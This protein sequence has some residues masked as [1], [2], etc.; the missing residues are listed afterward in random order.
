MA[1]PGLPRHDHY[2]FKETVRKIL[3]VGRAQAGNPKALGRWATIGDLKRT[4]IVDAG[5]SAR[6][7][8]HNAA[9][10]D[11]TLTNTSYGND[12]VFDTQMI[13]KGIIVTGDHEILISITLGFRLTTIVANT[14]TFLLKEGGDTIRDYSVAGSGS[15]WIIDDPAVSS[16]KGLK[17]IHLMAVTK[18][19]QGR[20]LY[21]LHKAGTAGASGGNVESG[22]IGMFFMELGLP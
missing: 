18:P 6:T 19:T 13:S 14:F 10:Q 2:S 5:F 22:Y 9:K 16:E 7:R 12:E 15:R 11:Q 17:N 21:T 20:K 1:F 3:A 8:L 4:N